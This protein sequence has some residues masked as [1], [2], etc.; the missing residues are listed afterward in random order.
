MTDIRWAGAVRRFLAALQFLTVIPVPTAFE[1]EEIGRSVPFFPLVGLAIGIAI[2]CLDVVVLRAMPRPVEAVLLVVLLAAASGG[3]HLDG[4]ADT[5]DGFLSSRP[6]ERI[7]E[8]MRDSRIGTMGVLGLFFVL[9]LK[10]AALGTLS[11][12]ATL[13]AIILAPLAGRCMLVLAMGTIPSARPEGLASVFLAHWKPWHA[14]WAVGF[15]GVVSLILFGW[16]GIVY[17]TVAVAVTLALNLYAHRKIGGITGDTLGA[18]CEC[19]EAGL[20]VAVSASAHAGWV[21]LL[22]ALAAGLAGLGLWRV[23]E[24][25]TENG[26]EAGA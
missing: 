25:R 6:K 13:G 8:I 12:P 11:G 18:A 7:L 20:L 2:A 23:R 19:A 3:L 15:L 16:R 24:R 1:P 10:A 4:L 26:K 17:A 21:M 9:G 14:A 22:A 5:A